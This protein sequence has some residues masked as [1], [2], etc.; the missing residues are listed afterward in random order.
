LEELGNPDGELSILFCGDAEIRGLN[1]EFRGIDKATD[2]LSFP[3]GEGPGPKTIGDIAISIP[4]ARRQAKKIGNSNERELLFLLVHGVLHLL[5][6]DH[7]RS[8][9]GAMEMEE[10]Q[11]KL[12]LAGYGRS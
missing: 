8:K 1:R 5:G 10:M 4:Y 9:K 3:G 12:M 11:R 7:E 6:Y 2:V